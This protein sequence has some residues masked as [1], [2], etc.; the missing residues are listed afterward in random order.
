MR[1]HYEVYRMLLDGLRTLPP[2]K[3]KDRAIEKLEESAFWASSAVVGE[4]SPIEYVT[5]DDKPRP[6]PLDKLKS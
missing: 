1:S 4:E 6:L 5:K 2:S 3:A